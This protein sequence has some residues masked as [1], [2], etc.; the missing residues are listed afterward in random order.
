MCLVLCITLSIGKLSL[1][2]VSW[3]QCCESFVKI[4]KFK[5]FKILL[6][7]YLNYLCQHEYCISEV[8]EHY[9]AFGAGLMS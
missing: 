1:L 6:L 7:V 2:L 9:F 8:Y 5:S 3:L 4:S